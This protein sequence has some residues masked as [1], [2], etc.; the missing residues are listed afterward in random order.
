MK[1]ICIGYSTIISILEACVLCVFFMLSL[2]KD[3]SSNLNL[4]QEPSLK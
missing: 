4:H 3:S 2:A 1:K